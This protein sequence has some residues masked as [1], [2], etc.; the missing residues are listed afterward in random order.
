MRLRSPLLIAAVLAF[1]APVG[2][3]WAQE[4]AVDAKLLDPSAAAQSKPKKGKQQA[5]AKPGESGK[6]DK[7]GKAENRQFGELEGWSPG[8]S[9]PKKKDD[10]KGPRSPSGGKAPVSMSPSGG[11]SVGMPF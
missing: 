9:P 1:I 5:A 2:A 11:M 10:D 7:G 8:K 4:L 3:A 6:T